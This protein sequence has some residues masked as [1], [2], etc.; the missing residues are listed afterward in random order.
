MSIVQSFKERVYA[1]VRAIPAGSVLTY[2]QVAAKAGNPKAARA[3]GTFMRINPK[4]FLNAANDPQVIPC[5]RVVASN[6]KLG[7]F[8]GGI[9]AKQRLLVAEGWQ[10]QNGMRLKKC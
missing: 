5:H 6:S 4:S 10:I 7:G 9:A 1:T 8:N 3:V 2:G